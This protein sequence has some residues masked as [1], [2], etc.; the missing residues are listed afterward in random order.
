[1]A[2]VD[3]A[4]IAKLM[5]REPESDPGIDRELAQL[6]AASRRRPPSR[7]SDTVITHRW[8]Q[9]AVGQP[10]GDLLELTWVHPGATR[11]SCAVSRSA[12]SAQCLNSIVM[13]ESTT[14]APGRLASV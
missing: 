6:G 9:D 12:A 4:G 1:M 3:C 8:P 10:G 13:R 14:G 5:G 2:A 11:S 7:S